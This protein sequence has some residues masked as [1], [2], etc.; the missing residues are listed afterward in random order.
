VATPTVH[1][2]NTQHAYDAALAA[3]VLIGLSWPT[4]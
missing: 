1:V 4:D 2:E 3:G